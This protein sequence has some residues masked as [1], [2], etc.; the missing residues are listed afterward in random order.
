MKRPSWVKAHVHAFQFFEGVSRLLVYDHF[1]TDITPTLSSSVRPALAR[2]IWP[3]RSALMPAMTTST[4]YM[5]L[6][7]MFA[8]YRETNLENK[9]KEFLRKCERTSVLILD[10]WPKK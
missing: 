2:P 7:D 8:A 1:Q 5:R 3:M 6:P 10:E 4:K 9:R